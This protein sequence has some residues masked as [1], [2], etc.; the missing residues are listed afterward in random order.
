VKPGVFAEAPVGAATPP[1]GIGGAAAGAGAG[2]VT[3]GG[4]VG[5]TGAGGVWLYVAL[6]ATAPALFPDAVKAAS[7]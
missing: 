4:V 5:T 2:C 6:E 3:G 7:F 1:A